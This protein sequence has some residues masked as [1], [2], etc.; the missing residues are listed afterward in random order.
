MI[1]A[2]TMEQRI[3][4]TAGAAMWSTVGYPEAGIPSL[5][6]AD[7]PMGIASG[8]VDERDIALLSPCPTA[9]GASWDVELNERVGALVGAEAIRMGVDMVLA[10]NVNL[11]R[12]PLAGRAFEYFSEEPVLAGVLG[13]AW[14]KGLQSTGTASV[15]KHLVCNDSETDRDMM[16]AVVDERTLREIYL[17][18]FEMCARAGAGGMLAAYNRLNG[19]WCAEQHHVL[20]TIVKGEWGYSGLIMSDWFGTH[21]TAAT[22]KGGLDLEMPGPARFLGFKAQ[23]ALAQGDVT[24]ERVSDAAARVA[25]AAHRFSGEKNAPITGADADALLVEA[26]AAGFV[27]LRNEGALLPLTPGRDKHIAIIGPNAAAPCYQGG[28]F[29][30]ISVAPGAARPLEAIL[31]RFGDHARVD[32]EP[33][34]DPQPRLPSMPVTPARDLGDGCATGMTI[35]YY[36]GQGDDARIVASETRDTNSLVWFAGVH[37]DVARL[38][39]PARIVARGR[40]TADRDG[41]HIFYLGATGP[42]TLRIDGQET[43]AQREP[44]PSS[45]VMGKLKSGDATS[46][47]APL[48][49]G[50]VVEV[51]VE[52]RYDPARVHGLWYGVRRPDTPEAMLARAVA[53]AQ[54]ADAVILIVG[55]TSD[56]SVESKDRAHTRLPGE[57]IA[58]IEAVAAANPRTAIVA[59]VGHAFDTSWEDQAAALLI[60]WYPGEGFGDA[61]AQVLAGDREPGGR[62]P[63]SIARTDADY[64]A[65]SLKPDANGDLL[66]AEGTRLGYR[67]MA[68]PLHTLGEGF[69]YADIALI[70]AAITPVDD[71]G[72]IVEATLENRSDR[73]GSDV[74]QLYRREPELALC[75]FTKAH[76]AAG[77]RRTVSIAV[78]RRQLQYWRDGWRDIE[79]PRLFLGRSARDVAYDLA[80]PL[81][82][83]V[84]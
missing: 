74:V 56:A 52:F 84:A 79:T 65:L 8:R 36:D 17:L 22:L 55:E 3:A 29:A 39:R 15:V 68:D 35:D 26:A 42:V 31:A 50:Q 62:M 18:P 72:V 49:A 20:T 21:S 58:L 70:D 69:G 5:S 34:V 1:D 24:P 9:L 30:K 66:Y 54:R 7:G 81:S 75:G 28:T 11:A 60:A 61:I 73:A 25:A 12:S 14:T 32:Y 27:L 40:F 76:L 10:P 4:M 6:M 46:T 37:D 57:Q 78:P 41:D 13:A 33:G 71:G 80:F 23:E 43:L 2:L 64:P 16:N 77:E 59:N 51:E 82:E 53:L 38:D 48:S 45:D 44:I 47:T 67:G 83:P 19:Q 63:V